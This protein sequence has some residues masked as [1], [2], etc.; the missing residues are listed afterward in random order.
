[1]L[2]SA[3]F[4][5][6]GVWFFVYWLLV[7]PSYEGNSSQSEWHVVL[8]FSGVLLLLAVVLPILARL[9]GAT[10]PVRA[11]LVASFG[12]A[13]SS[14]ANIVEDG[15]H[16]E[17]FFYVF[18]LGTGIMLLGLLGLTIAFLRIGRRR[19]RKLALVSAGTLAGIVLFVPAGGPILLASWLAA[20]AFA[21]ARPTTGTLSILNLP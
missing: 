13:L 20:T 19:D 6:V 4:A 9:E 15:L 10:V 14:G 1:V 17:S 12:A 16:V 5:L 11:A 3:L 7:D 8:S 21:H 2:R 18:V